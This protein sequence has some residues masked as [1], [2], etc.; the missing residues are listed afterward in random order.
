MAK[1]KLQYDTIDDVPDAHRELYEERDG[2]AHFAGVEGMRTDADVRAVKTA[3]EKERQRS[4]ELLKRAELL[5]D[6]DPEQLLR[7]AD[8]AAELRAEKRAR[9]EAEAGGKGGL[10]EDAIAKRVQAGIN[11]AVN[12][13]NRELVK[14]KAER[15][16]AAARAAELDSTIKAGTLR[17]ALTAAA[18]G[19]KVVPEAV[20]DV[21]ARAGLFEVGDDGKPVTRDGVGV[22]PGLS[23]SE[24]L[25]EVLPSKPHWSPMATG[26]GARGSGGGAAPGV[27]PFKR[28]T[29]NL[30]AC[31]DI[32]GR[33]PGKAEQLARLAG[34]ASVA[35]A[36][37]SAGR[38]AG[39]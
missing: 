36:M 16:A 6:R 34:H 12:P 24:W 23:P 38:A 13:L 28:E 39:R 25:T 29:F 33:D 21:L 8:E 2:K 30:A 20:D 19:A 32:A 5:G 1:L 3:A 18:L 9:E 7:D 4:K 37:A 17:S 10:G 11:S 14:L 31:G 15:D 26:G 22:T 35:A 27:N